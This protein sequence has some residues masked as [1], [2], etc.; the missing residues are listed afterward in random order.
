MFG[1]ASFGV[2]YRFAARPT[3][4]KVRYKATVTK[5]T[6]N[7]SGKGPLTTDDIDPARIF[8]CITDWTARHAV[9][10][11]KTYDES[12]F[13]NPN[14][15]DRLAEGPILGYGNRYITESTADWVEEV[16]P[17]YW[18]DTQAAPNPD[19]FTLSISCVTS[20][21][22]D[23]VTGSEN[24]LLFVEDFEWVY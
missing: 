23:Y 17:I 16:I 1:F 2:K 19:N 24:N 4:L 14:K 5:V 3:G 6:N 11:G 21:Y 18:Y 13:W 8:V 22:G 7:N 10:S 15:T 9:K 20:T 12:T